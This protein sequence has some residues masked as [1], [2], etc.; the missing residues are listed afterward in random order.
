[1]MI[2]DLDSNAAPVWSRTHSYFGKPFIW[3]T[4]HNFGGNRGVY[5]NLPRIA[6]GAIDALH[7]KGIMRFEDE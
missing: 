3:C 7:T 6:T 4:L 1:M 5:G 2:L